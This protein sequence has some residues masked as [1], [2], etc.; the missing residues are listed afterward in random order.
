MS[1]FIKPDGFAGKSS[2]FRAWPVILGL[3]SG[4]PGLSTAQDVPTSEPAAV[5]L[6]KITITGQTEASSYTVK[7]ASAATR[8]ELSP[9]ETPQSLTIVNR[10]RLDDQNLQSLRDVLDNT[11]GV[12]SYAYDSERVVFTSRGFFIDN[13]MYD[14]VPAAPNFSTDSLDDNLDTALYERVEIV[15]G[16]NGLMMGA[17]SPSAAVNL[18]RKHADS[19]NLSGDLTAQYGSWDDRRLSADLAT[20]L[21]AAGSVRARAIGVYQDQEN[22]QDLYSKKKKIFYGV[23]DADLGPRSLLTLGY[24]LQNTLPKANTWGSFPLFFSDGTRTDWSRSVTTATDWSFWNK[25][26]QTQFAEFSHAFENGWKLRATVNQR[27]FKEDLALFYVYGFPD[28]QTGEGLIPYAYRE[29]VNTTQNAADLYASGPF[30]LFGRR[31]E[32][33]LG[34][35][36]S[37]LRVKGQEYQHGTLA[38][39]GNFFE[40]DGRY[41][42]PDF[43]SVG[44]PDTNI[45]TRQTGLYAAA[46]LSLADPLKLILG[47]RRSTFK[48]DYYY[49][50]SG[51]YAQEQD[52]TVPY[53]GLIYDLSASYSAFASYTEIFNPQ[54]KREHSGRYLE[55]LSGKSY[56]FGLK[57]EHFDGRFNTALTLFNTRQ[58]NVAE[59]DLDPLTGQQR[60]VNDD[61]ITPAA[62]AVDGTRSRG[63]EL[64]AS[65]TPLEGWNLSL[66]ASRYLLQ[67]PGDRNIRPYIPRTLLRSFSAWT[68][69]GPLHALTVGGGVNWQSSSHLDVGSPSGLSNIRQSPVTLMSLMARWQITPQ[70]SAQLNGENLLDRKYYVLDEYGNLYF[71]TPLNAAASLRY[72]F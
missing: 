16:A 43:D 12:Y 38:E 69:P 15:R 68:L 24:D 60:Y 35:N 51:S 10:E 28:P 8:L 23:I 18:V 29:K 53:A 20:P 31:H 36:G 4:L 41:P 62:V 27:R 55:P 9:R 65:G 67:A 63:F 37:K 7:Q 45:D 32:L 57:G 56:E 72:R 59:N 44:T 64:E 6:N 49:L 40:W 58:D 66:G 17:G 21:N 2:S 11:S 14:G 48:T 47:A 30:E 25:R 1:R 46:R 3:L 39:V 13:L 26:K 61:G 5:T 71:G 52:K 33:V 22:Y 42:M 54:N 50:Y 70:L 34:F 19:R